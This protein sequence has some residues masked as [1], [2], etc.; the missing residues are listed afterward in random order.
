MTST[1]KVKKLTDKALTEANEKY[2]KRIRPLLT[3]AQRF[4][5]QAV[6]IMK[7]QIHNE[8]AYVFKRKDID[9][10]EDVWRGTEL[11]VGEESFLYFV[12]K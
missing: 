1:E 6:E 5:P 8:Y 11:I 2:E 12:R 10:E 4:G 9:T 7:S 3:F